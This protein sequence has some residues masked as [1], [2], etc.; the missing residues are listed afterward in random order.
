MPSIVKK[1]LTLLRRILLLADFNN[2]DIFILV[3]TH[4]VNDFFL[5]VH[6]LLYT[7]RAL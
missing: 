2:L 7:H 5:L 6:H 3:F 4:F 1:D